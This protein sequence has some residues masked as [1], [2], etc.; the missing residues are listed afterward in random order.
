MITRKQWIVPIWENNHANCSMSKYHRY[1]GILSRGARCNHGWAL[2]L[3]V[4]RV[5]TCLVRGFVQWCRC[6]GRACNSSN[7]PCHGKSDYM[8]TIF[9]CLGDFRLLRGISNCTKSKVVIRQGCGMSVQRGWLVI[10]CNNVHSLQWHREVLQSWHQLS[11]DFNGYFIC[12]RVVVSLWEW[13]LYD[14]IWSKNGVVGDETRK[15]V[16]QRRGW[17]M[18]MVLWY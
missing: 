16:V 2:F 6:F 7:A 15:W 1:N 5:V 14:E 3:R 17:V 8:V 13:I 4:V 11:G 9:G 18:R 12:F 10:L